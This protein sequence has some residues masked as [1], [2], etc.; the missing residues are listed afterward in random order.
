MWIHCCREQAV[1]GQAK[2]LNPFAGEK[3]KIHFEKEIRFETVLFSHLKEKVIKALLEVHPYEEVAYDIYAL[4][5]D[6][7]EVGLGCVGEFDEA[8]EL[9][10][11]F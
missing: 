11:I 5:N 7:I 4:E 2:T 1:S 6:N 8:D 10:L 9:K 3:G